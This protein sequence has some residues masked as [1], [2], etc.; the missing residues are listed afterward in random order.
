MAAKLGDF[1]AP[2]IKKVTTQIF[3]KMSPCFQFGKVICSLNWNWIYG[4]F[5]APKAALS[6]GFTAFWKNF[7][8]I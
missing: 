4:Y 7:T 3:L 5:C 6:N 2:Q 8:Q 1:G